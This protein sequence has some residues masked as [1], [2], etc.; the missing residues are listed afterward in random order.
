MVALVVYILAAPDSGESQLT[1]KMHK[2]VEL[3]GLNEQLAT[4]EDTHQVAM[5]F[6]HYFKPYCNL[7]LL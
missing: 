2:K 5:L 3:K 7:K 1:Q 6:M 4:H